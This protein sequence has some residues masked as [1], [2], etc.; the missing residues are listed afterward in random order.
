MSQ[1][2]HLLKNNQDTA[3][4]EAAEALW[5]DAARDSRRRYHLPDQFLW[6]EADLARI[7]FDGYMSLV[8][9]L[10]PDAP[11]KILDAGC[12]PGLTTS[13]MAQHGYQMTGI[14]YNDRAIAFAKI[15]VPDVLFSQQDLRLLGEVAEFENAFDGAVIV[16]VF[17]HIPPQYHETVLA[18]LHRVLRP[19]G[20]LILSVPGDRMPLNAWDY[21]HFGLQEITDLM[22]LANFKVKQ[23]RFQ[24]RVHWLFSGKTWRFLTNR[25]Y[26][27]R[28]VRKWLRGLFLAQYNTTNEPHQAGRYIVQ[29]EKTD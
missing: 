14:D 23:V 15:L 5:D 27:V 17:E 7:D 3:A 28:F 12:G 19:N 13:L 16:E 18:G 20:T 10:L 4:P 11:M 2:T 24:H 6:D 21:K 9:Q 8:L 1:E 25:Y 22:E 29:A 26:D